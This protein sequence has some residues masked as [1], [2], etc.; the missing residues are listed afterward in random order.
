MST[1][2]EKSM[3]IRELENL[4]LSINLAV[5]SL[6]FSKKWLLY[7]FLALV[8]MFL[9]S[10][11]SNPLLQNAN[12]KEAYVDLFIGSILFLFFTF[13]CLLLALPVSSDEISDRF[14]ELILV[15]PVRKEVLWISRWIVTFASVFLLNFMIATAY[16][17][18]FHVV[19]GNA[20][21]PNDL[22]NNIYLL[23]STALLLVAATLIY[24]G[25]FLTVAFLGRKGLGIGI[26]LAIFELIFSNML[27]LQDEPIMPRTNLQVIADEVFGSLFTY[28]PDSNKVAPELWFSWTYAFIAAVL[29]FIIGMLYLKYREYN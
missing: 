19:D 2:R 14:F 6:M 29:F 5:K 18:Y 26:L 28:T 4:V 8:P 21:M 12:A 25:L 24:S 7:A 23:Q 17:V 20:K 3:I 9:L 15:R 11:T 27:F 10:L 16:Y 1:I 22:I 13:S